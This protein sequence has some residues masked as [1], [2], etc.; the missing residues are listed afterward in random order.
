MFQD[1]LKSWQEY[2]DEERRLLKWLLEK[3]LQIEDMKY[4][5]LG[6]GEVVKKVFKMFMVRVL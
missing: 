6:D 1:V 5:D 4:I 2:R 3:E